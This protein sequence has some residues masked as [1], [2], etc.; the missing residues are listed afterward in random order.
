MCAITG[1]A[2][3]LKRGQWNL[4][5]H[6]LTE[7]FV[8]SAVRGGDAAGFA[9]IQPGPK[10]Q[11]LV[12]DKRPVPSTLFAATSPA[13]AKLRSPSCVIAHCRA[14][15]HGSPHAPDNMNNHPFVNAKDSLGVVVNGISTNYLD[16]ADEY[17]LPLRSDCDS[18]VILRLVEASGHP[19]LGLHTCLRELRGGMAAAVLDAERQM[20]WLAR[21][22][23]RPLWLLRLGGIE[24]FFFCSTERIALQAL[25]KVFG[26]DSQFLLEVLVPLAP[27]TVTGISSQG[28]WI[29]PPDLSP[30]EP[31][32]SRG[33]RLVAN[34]S[35][36][37][38]KRRG[39][40]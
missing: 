34:D 37:P 35:P 21:N 29:A 8:T 4:V 1:W 36:A 25:R 24:G 16:V 13:W 27:K 15:T 7:L 33:L 12:T 2:G 39:K 14:A 31:R 18:E 10:G 23:S 6:L 38:L 9:A 22:E 19:A 30:P 40:R 32:V 3:H 17:G 28:H 26:R 20:V 5:H 11:R